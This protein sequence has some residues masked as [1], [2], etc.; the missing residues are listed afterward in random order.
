MK[1]VDEILVHAGAVG[2]Q[3]F[4]MYIPTTGT[5]L[6]EIGLLRTLTVTKNRM[7]S[8]FGPLFL[9]SQSFFGPVHSQHF[10][11]IIIHLVVATSVNHSLFSR[12]P[13][14]DQY[15]TKILIF[16]RFVAVTST[17]TRSALRS[18]PL[19][20]RSRVCTT[21]RRRIVRAN[22]TGG[23]CMSMSDVCTQSVIRGGGA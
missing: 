13:F 23:S 14:W 20:S 18:A 6:E 5:I 3:F 15:S 8:A 17:H 19:R 12:S 9:L 11:Y 7:F 4:S 22:A 16:F 1:F 10:D 21:V 2:I